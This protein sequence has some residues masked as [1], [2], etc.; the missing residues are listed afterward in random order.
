MD[1]VRRISVLRFPARSYQLREIRCI[2]ESAMR[3]LGC[4]EEEIN[5]IVL[6]INEACM[7]IIQHAYGENH[8]GEIILEIFKGA[9]EVLF[10]ITDF[11]KPVDSCL[12][13]SRSLAEIRPG[14]LGVH[15]IQE[16]M[17]SVEFKLPDNGIGNILE[18]RKKINC[19][20]Q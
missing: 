6:A 1:D 13:K 12:I 2:V 5:A 4:E 14:G 7:N 11:A 16:V 8:G 15:I 18:M 19:Q 17:D 10:R 9:S 20:D 3:Q